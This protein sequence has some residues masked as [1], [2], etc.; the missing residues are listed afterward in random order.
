MNA[1]LKSFSFAFQGLR[2]A[3]HGRNFRIQCA[4]AI[5][6]VVAGVM[7]DISRGE[8]A[9]L[10][11]ITGLVL[12]FE[13][14]N[15]AIENIVNFISPEFHPLAGKIKDLAAASVLILSMASLVIGALIFLPYIFNRV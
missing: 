15:T 7:L 9:V 8:W 2:F 14:M 3:W 11:I 6:V 13:V 5:V 4:S 10:S 12:A 1:F